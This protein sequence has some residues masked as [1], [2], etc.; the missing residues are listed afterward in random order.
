MANLLIE[1]QMEE[2]PSRMQVMAE[3]ELKS[4]FENFCK[5]EQLTVDAITISSTPRRLILQASNLPLKQLDVQKELRGPRLDAPTQ[6]LDGFL[7][8]NSLKKEDCSTLDTPKGQFWMANVTIPGKTL[9]QCVDVFL[10]Q[11]LLT[12]P[13]AKTMRW[14]SVPFRWVRPLHSILAMIDGIPKTGSVL[15]IPYVDTTWGHRFLGQAISPSLANESDYFAFLDANYVMK[16]REK[17]RAYIEGELIQ[18][19]QNLGIQL[20]QDPALMEEVV[21]LIEYPHLLIGSID[22]EFMS[23]PKELIISVMKTQQRYFAFYNGSELA[24]Y[25]GVVANNLKTKSNGTIVKAGNEKVLR[26]RLSDGQ[27]YWASDCDTG[28]ESFAQKLDSIVFHKELGSI[29][30]KTR[31]MEHI[32]LWMNQGRLSEED[33]SLAARLCKSDLVS[34]VVGEF[35][36]LQGIIG[37]YL[38]ALENKP[39]LKAALS[40][41]YKPLGP[42]DGLP[43]DELGTLLAFADKL[44]TLVGFFAINE[45]PTG[46]KDPFALRRS[47][48]GILRLIESLKTTFGRSITLNV[49]KLVKTALEAYKNVNSL[50]FNEA[51]VILDIQHFLDERLKAQFKAEGFKP[52]YITAVMSAFSTLDPSDIRTR[53]KFVSAHL[54]ETILSAY[55]RLWSISKIVSPIQEALLSEPSEKELYVIWKQSSFDTLENT[56]TDFEKLAPFIH[57]FFE[58]VTVNTDNTNQKQNRLALVASIAESLRQWLHLE[59]IQ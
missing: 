36:E 2:I 43:S 42:N 29:A 44:D 53:L 39:Q 3:N 55:S 54:S 7:N 1:L 48:L 40:D 18:A 19:E 37:G 31:R 22:Q 56:F 32:I 5:N 58:N 50:L 38:A 4:S 41:H 28:L 47:A 52:D 23:L 17:R 9:S 34:G 8:S 26:A 14:G 33:L 15:E 20:H 35:P 59:H 13:W 46:S 49:S 24:P 21:G 45:K 51:N 6:A 30:Q 10:E 12:F 25:F 57:A 27:F 16:D 11:L